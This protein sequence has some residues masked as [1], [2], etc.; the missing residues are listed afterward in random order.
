M[1]VLTSRLTLIVAKSV[2]AKIIFDIYIWND[3]LERIKL[4]FK[5]LHK[6]L[7]RAP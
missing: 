2:S 3:L 4:K 6:E 5:C 7:D 1:C